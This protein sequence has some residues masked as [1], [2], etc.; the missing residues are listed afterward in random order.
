MILRK[1]TL[2][3]DSLR[4]AG[5][6]LGSNMAS[7]HL[8]RMGRTQET[9]IEWIATMVLA[10]SLFSRNEPISEPSFYILQP[11]R[12]EQIT[13][14]RLRV[15]KEV[16]AD[17]TAGLHSPMH[18]ISAQDA[19]TIFIRKGGGKFA[20]GWGFHHWASST[21]PDSDNSV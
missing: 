15:S 3:I 17:L 18:S 5:C 6:Q 13:G 8:F 20:K 1:A 16:N 2:P 14:Q 21:N 12:F 9:R 11:E 10:I 7:A 19:V 4:L